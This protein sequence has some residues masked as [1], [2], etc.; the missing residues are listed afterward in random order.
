MSEAL[1]ARFSSEAKAWDNNPGHIKSSQCALKAIQERIPE[2]NRKSDGTQNGTTEGKTAHPPTYILRPLLTGA[3]HGSERLTIPG[4]DVLEIGCGTGLL[5]FMIGPHVRSLIG[6]DTAAGMI[7][8]FTAKLSLP[9]NPTNLA[10]CLKLLES[11]DDPLLQST[12]STLSHKISNK[13]SSNNT[14]F[15]FR[16]DLIISHLTLHH[17]PSLEDILKLMYGCLKEGGRVALTDF[18][19]Y[20]EEAV[21]FHQK[22]KREGCERHGIHRETTEG[23]MRD[24][25][26]KDVK[27]DEAF[28]LE[29]KVEER[30]E[31]MW[32]PFVVCYG[33]K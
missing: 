20:G 7:D 12:A 8:A 33:R 21:L 28:R 31:K 24:A 13:P 17:I 16:F 26:F 5:S 10:P 32:F 11:P 2:L 29:K 6:A 3:Y 23:L 15:P 22:S 1:N 4:L 30:E 9:S 25:G 18:E 14:E 19:D 27:V